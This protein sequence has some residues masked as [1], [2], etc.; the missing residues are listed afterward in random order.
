MS[1]GHPVLWVNIIINLP[2]LKLRPTIIINDNFFLLAKVSACNW[3]SFARKDS[4]CHLQGNILKQDDW[5]E[6]TVVSPCKQSLLWS[7]W[8]RNK[9][10]ALLE[11]SQTFE[12]ATAQTSG[13]D[14]LVLSLQTG[15]FEC[16]IH[17]FIR[18]Y[19]ET[20][21]HNQDRCSKCM[22][23]KPRFKTISQRHAVHVQQRSSLIHAESFQVCQNQASLIKR[24][25]WQGTCCRFEAKLW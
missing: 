20:Y 6:I 2:P 1:I 15:F 4:K 17:Y 7:S 12:V 10:A 25:C 19:W 3:V 24:F 23:I 5:I 13:P 14:N 9:K 22:A 8:V 18:V 16:S 21:G 11:S